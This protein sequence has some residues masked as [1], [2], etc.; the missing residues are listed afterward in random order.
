MLPASTTPDQEEYT[1]CQGV[2]VCVCVLRG[3]DRWGIQIANH[4]MTV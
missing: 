1:Y 3:N 4:S 2:C